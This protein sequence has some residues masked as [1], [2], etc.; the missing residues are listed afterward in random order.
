[1]T[2]SHNTQLFSYTWGDA[3]DERPILLNGKRFW[4]GKN[5]LSF[6]RQAA[7]DLRDEYIDRR[8]YW[9]DAICINQR[10]K[11]EKGWQIG[12][13]GRIYKQA[14]SLDIWFGPADDNTHYAFELLNQL[15]LDR[16]L[17]DSERSGILQVKV[18]CG[19]TVRIMS[20]C[21]NED[22]TITP[23]VDLVSHRWWRRV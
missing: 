21:E 5:L 9:I 16:A 1:L 18:A 10:D 14:S 2:A 6:L 11:D 8:G 7:R 22:T 23:L 4:V 20:V 17:V 13:M 19:T 3:T 12:M 15:A